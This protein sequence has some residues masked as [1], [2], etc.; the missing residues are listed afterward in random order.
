MGTHLNIISE[1][2]VVQNNF[3]N[4][5]YGLAGAQR[6]PVL[7]EGTGGQS[8]SSTGVWVRRRMLNQRDLRELAEESEAYMSVNDQPTYAVEHH[9]NAQGRR[10]PQRFF[11]VEAV[12]S[13]MNPSDNEH[14]VHH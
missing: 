3:A 10:G 12:Q 4:R 9:I 7:L 5:N 1:D 8:D 14:V 6:T 2:D 11:L 13:D